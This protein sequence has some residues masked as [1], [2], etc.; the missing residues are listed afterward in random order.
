MFYRSKSREETDGPAGGKE[1]RTNVK[2][3]KKMSGFWPMPR[4]VKYNRKLTISKLDK[5]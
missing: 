4:Y 3:G 5:C 1:K 2:G